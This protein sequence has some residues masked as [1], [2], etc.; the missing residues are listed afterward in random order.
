[1]FPNVL[2]A[3]KAGSGKDT[4]GDLLCNVYGYERVS[5]AAP[6]K[7][8][9]RAIWPNLDW[10]KKQRPV[11]QAFGS[12]CRDI[13]ALTWVRL[14]ERD[15]SAWNTMNIP[16]VVTDCR[17]LNEYEYFSARQWMCIYL[18]CSHELRVQRL[19]ARDGD[20]DLRS[21]Q[22]ASECDLD[23]IDVIHVNN[24]SSVHELNLMVKYLLRL[25]EVTMRS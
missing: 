5:F 20:C 6:L 16:V 14:A 15:A 2:V 9:A 17:Y 1:M 23:N 12:A 18:D 21:L 22:H 10:T 11:L 3:G 4:V 13:D 24:E 25:P 8:Q 19:I 7:E